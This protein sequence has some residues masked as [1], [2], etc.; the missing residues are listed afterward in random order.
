MRR[1]L[2]VGGG[3]GG[4]IFPLIAV[5]QAIQEFA[6]QNSIKIDL[7]VLGEGRFIRQACVENNLKFK[8]VMGAKW[9]R[10]FSVLNFIDL[11]KIPVAFIQ[12]LWHIYWYMPDA[13]FTKGSYASIIPALS[14]R[15]YFIPVFTHESDSV[16][17]RANVIIAS[18]AKKVFISFKSAGVFFKREKT[19]LTGNPSRRELFTADKS[20]SLRFFNFDGSK[21]IV[22]VTG[23]SQGAGVINSIILEALPSL[24]QRYHIIHQCGDAH[25]KNVQEY[26]SKLGKENP[27]I[28]SAI[29][30]GYRPLPFLPTPDLARAY[31]ASDIVISRAGAANIFEI[32]N[33]GKPAVII[34][35]SESNGNHQVVNALEFSKFGAVVIEESNLTPNILISQLGRLLENAQEVGQKINEFATPDAGDRIASVLCSQS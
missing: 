31:A 19:I 8:S 23:G 24:L 18:W 16:P 34:P 29:Q 32:A 12:S 1:I 22:F 28:N 17:G 35:I 4:H 15:L 21:K 26:I 10:Y 6:R 3:T 2:L 5:A 25:I 9:R 20:D 30:N 14:A 11:L 13:V 27:E 33:M 7:R